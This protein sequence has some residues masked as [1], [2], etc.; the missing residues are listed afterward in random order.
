MK[1]THIT[2]AAALLG[3]ALSLTGCGFGTKE[4]HIY[5]ENKS[6]QTI[7]LQQ[8]SES[9][10]IKVTAPPHVTSESLNS[11]PS[12]HCWDNWQI[13]DENGKV[14]R[15]IDRVCAEDHIVYP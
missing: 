11:P 13:V 10:T 4:P 15:E 6:D 8:P 3:I 12:G 2:S 14:L 7:V 9:G 1:A 5:L